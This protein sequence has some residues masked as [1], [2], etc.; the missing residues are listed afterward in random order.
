[1]LEGKKKPRTAGRELS[2]AGADGKTAQKH[3][4]AA[5]LLS[6]PEVSR[7]AAVIARTPAA[8]G[9]AELDANSGHSA[10]H[11]GTRA[12]DGGA[13]IIRPPTCHAA[14]RSAELVVLSPEICY[15]PEQRPHAPSAALPVV[16]TM[17]VR[18][19]TCVLGVLWRRAG[20]QAPAGWAGCSG[21]PS[22]PTPRR[23]GWVPQV[24]LVQS[25]LEPERGVGADSAGPALSVRRARN[26]FTSHCRFL[27]TLG[28]PD[29]QTTRSTDS[30][31]QTARG[32]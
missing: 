19:L 2:T 7:S 3:P 22:S 14:H 23:T 15:G 29:D 24:A 21:C 4:T 8:A 12:G 17:S 27:S 31:G 11:T 32:T 10:A 9:R 16:T 28:S 30:V 20:P 26:L 5:P 25:R 13:T 6:L 1:M 18:L